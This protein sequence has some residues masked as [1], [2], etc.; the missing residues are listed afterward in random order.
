MKKNDGTRENRST[1]S[2]KER[3]DERWIGKMKKDEKNERWRKKDRVKGGKEV[4]IKQKD[5]KDRT[6]NKNYIG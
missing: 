2:K 6:F 4:K 3:K 5:M 1:G